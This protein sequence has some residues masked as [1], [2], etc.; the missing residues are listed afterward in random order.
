MVADTQMLTG[1]PPSPTNR[2][3]GDWDGTICST[4]ASSSTR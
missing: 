4:P 1:G 2:F 3:S